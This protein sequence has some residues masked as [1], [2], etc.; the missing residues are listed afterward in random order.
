ML[1]EWRAPLMEDLE[2]Q[3]DGFNL[4]SLVTGGH[5]DFLSR[6]A[7]DWELGSQ[8]LSWCEW[9]GRVAG[10]APG[11]EV[12]S[13][14][15]QYCRPQGWGS[16]VGWDRVKGVFPSHQTD[17]P[18]PV[19]GKHQVG[20]RRRGQGHRF[21]RAPPPCQAFST[22]LILSGSQWRPLGY[23]GNSWSSKLMELLRGAAVFWQV[24]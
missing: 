13:V 16:R 12:G 4:I 23:Q 3:L 17:P 14:T 8:R 2:S 5:C 22:S 21:Y 10:E 15:Q 6:K 9:T 20:G 7:A 19:R 18:M 1:N 24:S 11:W